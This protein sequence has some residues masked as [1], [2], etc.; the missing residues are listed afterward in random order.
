MLSPISSCTVKQ[1]SVPDSSVHTAS[2]AASFCIPDW[3]LPPSTFQLLSIL[4]IFTFCQRS[5]FTHF[6]AAIQ[7]SGPTQSIIPKFTS[8]SARQVLTR[9]AG[10]WEAKAGLSCTPR[11]SDRSTHRAAAPARPGEPKAQG[12]PVLHRARTKPCLCVLV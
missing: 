6:L 7:D 1:Q 10:C 11:Y 8:T 12:P 2:K 5:C 4:I 9:K 3:L